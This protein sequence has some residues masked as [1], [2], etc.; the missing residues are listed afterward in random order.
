MLRI[1]DSR[2]KEAGDLV[3]TLSTLEQMIAEKSMASF[4]APAYRLVANIVSMRTVEAMKWCWAVF[5]LKIP[6]IELHA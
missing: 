3:G 2:G 4:Q 5:R 1:E 6:H